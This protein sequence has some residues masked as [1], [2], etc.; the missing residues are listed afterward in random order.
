VKL[1]FRKWPQIPRFFFFFDAHIHSVVCP[2]FRGAL[3]RMGLKK[4]SL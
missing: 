1:L 2:S 4:K 3:V